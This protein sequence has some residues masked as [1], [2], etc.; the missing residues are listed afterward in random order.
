MV[1]G[2]HRSASLSTGHNIGHTIS[3]GA[4]C[5]IDSGLTAPDSVL[6]VSEGAITIGL[7]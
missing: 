3:N 4:K 5:Y 7:S 2:D 6:T 1:V